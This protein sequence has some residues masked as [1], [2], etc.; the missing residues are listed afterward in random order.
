MTQAATLAG[1]ASSGALSADSSGNV[2][3]GTTT[4]STKLQVNG[5]AT[6]TTFSGSGASL[7]SLN[8]SNISSGTLAAARLPAGGVLQVVQAVKT[9]TQSFS[10]TYA[11][12]TGLSVTLTPAAASSKFLVSVVLNGYP[13]HY[14]GYGRILRNGTSIGEAAAAGSRN[15]S[16]LPFSSPPS[17]DGPI[18][19]AAAMFLDSPNTTSSLT[20]KVQGIGRADG[21]A[22][23]L[24]Y[25]GRTVQDRNT[26]TYD[27]R[28]ICSI[29]V[30]E[31]A[32]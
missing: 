13:S 23:G 29:T 2:G 20:Y 21:E 30:M 10:T 12:V 14:I 5:T 32:G 24:L 26:A 18:Q 4:P 31:I 25:L 1:L 28:A 7:T 9:D 8:A 3:I 19:T 17:S 22:G 6:A 27:P 16:P 11:D 15:T